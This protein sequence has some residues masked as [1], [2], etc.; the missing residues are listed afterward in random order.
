MTII[1]NTE[2]FEE[3]LKRAKNI[4]EDITSDDIAVLTQVIAVAAERICSQLETIDETIS[5][6]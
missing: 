2:I 5:N 3:G 1:Y 6:K 4:D